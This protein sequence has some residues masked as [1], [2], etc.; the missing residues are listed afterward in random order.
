PY[1]GLILSFSVMGAMLLWLAGR[2]RPTMKVALLQVLV[3]MAVLLMLGAVS[4]RYY[5]YPVTGNP[6]PMNYPVNPH[7][8]PDSPHF[9][10]GVTPYRAFVPAHRNARFLPVGTAA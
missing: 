4:T 10:L 5:Y 9:P 2:K 3:P 8:Y 7:A 6:F 1:E